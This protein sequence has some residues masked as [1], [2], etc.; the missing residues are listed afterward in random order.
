MG[1]VMAFIWCRSLQRCC[2]L[3][4]LLEILKTKKTKKTLAAL[5]KKEGIPD[6]DALFFKPKESVLFVHKAQALLVNVS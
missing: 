1:N 2:I 5:S 4:H 3:K 6:S